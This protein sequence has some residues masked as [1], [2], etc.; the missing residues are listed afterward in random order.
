MKLPDRPLLWF[1]AV[2]PVLLVV[3]FLLPEWIATWEKVDT[4]K[5]WVEFVT[6]TRST[7]VTMVG[8]LGFIATALLTVQNLV[9]AQRNIE[10]GQKN[11]ELAQQQATTTAFTKAVEQL[12]SE[13]VAE[14]LG[15]VYSLRRI[16]KSAPNEEG[17]AMQILSGYLRDRYANHQESSGPF[18]CPVEVQAALNAIGTRSV[19]GG[20]NL[21][22]SGIRIAEAWLPQ[23]Y[24]FSNMYFWDV[25]LNRWNLEQANLSNSDFKR[26]SFDECDFSEANFTNASLNN[27]TLIRCVFTDADLTGADFAA[28]KVEAPIGLTSEQLSSAKNAAHIAPSLI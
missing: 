14:R 10:L 23:G 12:G 8:G 16:A 17:S 1:V 4:R 20:F 27:A 5:E 25:H 28:A 18:Q 22:L 6:S 7:L 19:A 21:D 15:G 26:A 3:V 13:R 24:D 9:L 2:V 11:L